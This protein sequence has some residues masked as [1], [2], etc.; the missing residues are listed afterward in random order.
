MHGV[1]NPGD[2]DEP[3]GE[4]TAYSP[5]L[6]EDAFAEVRAVGG[7]A[8]WIGLAVGRRAFG[9]GCVMLLLRNSF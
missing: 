8:G 7:V 9:G 6:V 5:K 4:S 1:Q 3:R 2:F